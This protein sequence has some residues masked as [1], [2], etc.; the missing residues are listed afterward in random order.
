MAL[1]FGYSNSKIKK[2]MKKLIIAIV[3]L[4]VVVDAKSQ[5]QEELMQFLAFAKTKDSLITAAYY[6]KDVATG[7]K[8]MDEFVEKYNRLSAKEQGMFKQFLEGDYYNLAC[9]YSL[10]NDK[11]HALEYLEKSE[12]SDY[13]HLME[14]K[15]MD[16]LR[17]D[18]RFI[19]CLKLAKSKKVDYLA[20]LQQAPKYSMNEN[21]GT[22]EFTYQSPDD[23]NLV[24]L[25]KTFNLDS[26]A[27]M[28]TDVSKMIN[29]MRWVHNL[30]PHDGSNGNPDIKNAMSFIT[31]CKRD[32]KSLNCRGLAILLNEVYLAE[33][34][35]SR[36]V[37]CLPKDST[38]QDCHVITAVWSAS[39]KKWIWMDPTFNA[40]VMNEK[41]ELLGL[42][43]VRER[44][45]KNQPL[46]LNPDADHNRENSQ[47]KKYYLENYMAKNL[48]KL[49][50]PVKS[51][52]DY[53][54]FE[55]GKETAYT[56]LV[57]GGNLPQPLVVKNKHG[58][59]ASTMYYSSN[60]KDFWA[61]P[62]DQKKEYEKAML[63]FKKFYN[64]KQGDS[65]T[66]LCSYS[67]S[68][69]EFFKPEAVNGL[70]QKYGH[71]Q[72]YSF[73][74]M[75]EDPDV[76]LFKLEFDNSKIV[77]GFSLNSQNKIETFRLG[78]SSSY[79]NNLLAKVK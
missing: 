76:A 53:E 41:G 33:G 63:K 43:E 71:L 40:Y 10:L 39:F 19:K 12:Y 7:K 32:H 60:P 8:N 55:E 64:E 9:T 72:S 67:N 24:K 35:K 78:T 14:D 21:S 74:G 42:E 75:D 59:V 11:K 2:D 52:Y 6:A 27:G 5:T 3:I 22:P 62:L 56:I 49:Q 15:D 16:I 38:D 44:L 69:G 25:R 70:F 17:K 73:L 48:Y 23:T 45:I 13:D 57:P 28:G 31:V 20:T 61:A 51:E 1:F 79:I 68:W 66:A 54:T 29:L 4:F 18:P 26:I 46:I 36:F 30:I 58:V 47:T 77:F 65:L 37:T 34:F 50:C